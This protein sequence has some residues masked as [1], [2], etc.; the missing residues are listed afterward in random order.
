MEILH[1][2]E[3]KTIDGKEYIEYHKHKVLRNKTI[4][5]SI[6]LGLLFFALLLMVIAIKTI[7][8]NKE[9]LENQPIDY[10]IQQ[11]DL[12][13]CSCYNSDGSLFIQE[14]SNFGGGG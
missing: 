8:E 6:F 7:I 12:A 11:Y 13:S 2:M 3:T 1:K 14:G 10:L 4:I 9:M 5:N